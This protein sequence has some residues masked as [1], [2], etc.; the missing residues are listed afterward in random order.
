[1]KEL[2]KELK[3]FD[4]KQQLVRENPNITNRLLNESI[5]EIIEFYEGNEG[6]SEFYEKLDNFEGV[7]VY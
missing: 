3:I 2:E 5:Q 7:G 6:L 4:A 1:M